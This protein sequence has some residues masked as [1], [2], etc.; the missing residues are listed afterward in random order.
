MRLSKCLVAALAVV[1]PLLLLGCSSDDDDPAPG[2]GAGAGGG[3]AGAGGEFTFTSPS[4][5]P[6]Q[7]LPDQFTCNDKAFG[8]GSSPE[9][10]WSEEPAGTKSYAILLKDYAIESGQSAD[11]NPEHAFHWAI[12][13]IPGTT[14]KLE[15][16]LPTT[17]SPVEGTQQQN[18]GPPFI[19]PGTFGYFGPCPNLG[20][21]G[22]GAPLETHGYG[23]VLY[24]F[25][26]EMLTPPAY[27]PGTDA[28]NPLNPVHQLADFFENNPSLL[29]RDWL[30][31]TSDA[32]PNTC[33][34]F[35]NPPFACAPAAP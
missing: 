26:E 25:S 22:M 1:A 20:A 35:P 15:A 12:W 34:G 30:K 9:F 8:D 24:A 3:S 27:D 19:S 10:N 31:F 18:G 7:L 16:S 17:Q 23:F 5:H 28:D 13:N 6:D 32:K 4:I 33:P 29:D 14:H 2:G 11:T 21:A